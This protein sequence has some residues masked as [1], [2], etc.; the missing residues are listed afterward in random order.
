MDSI[1]ASLEEGAPGTVNQ[2]TPSGY[3]VKLLSISVL[4]PLEGQW[5]SVQVVQVDQQQKFSYQRKKWF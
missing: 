2:R 4:T 3:L 5:S 1:E